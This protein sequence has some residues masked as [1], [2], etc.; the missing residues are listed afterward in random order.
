[1]SRGELLEDVIEGTIIEVIIKDNGE[2][3]SARIFEDKTET[4]RQRV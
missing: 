1:V 3:F 4:T 2:V